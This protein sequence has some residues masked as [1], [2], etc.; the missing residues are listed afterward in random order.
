MLRMVSATG[1]TRGRR[2]KKVIITVGM[3][4]INTTILRHNN[5]QHMIAKHTIGRQSM[6]NLLDTDA[7]LQLPILHLFVHRQ[8][9]LQ[10]LPRRLPCPSPKP[11]KQMH[12]NTAFH[13]DT[14]SRIGIL[15]K[16]PSCS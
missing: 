5:I 9:D 11:Q 14:H 4:L 13:L 12:A 2:R 3:A 6:E 8:H 16:N 1:C 7:N 15:Q 10:H